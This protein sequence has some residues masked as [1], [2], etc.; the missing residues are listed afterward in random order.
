MADT[1]Y[2]GFGSFDP[3]V[4]FARLRLG[5]LLQ[6]EGRHKHISEL[7]TGVDIPGLDEG[8]YFF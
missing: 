2:P 3:I 6:L 1:C 7:P 8:N 4:D 5:I